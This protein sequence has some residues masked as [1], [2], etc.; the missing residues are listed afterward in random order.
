MKRTILVAL[1]AFA[2]APVAAGAAAPSAAQNASS[3]CAALKAKMGA[4][5]F[6][7]AYA[8]F[9]Q[10]VSALTP[11]EQQNVNG[12]QDACVAEQSDTN[13]AAT[14]GGKTFAQFY[15]TGKNGKD[16]LGKCVSSKAQ[17][18][19]AAEQAGTPNP[20]QTCRTQRT[21]MGTK[22]FDKT[23]GKNANDR[24]AF[25]KCVSKAAHAQAQNES[26]AATLCRSE[27]SDSNFASSHGGKTFAQFYG[28]NADD[29]NAF[30]QCV[31]TKTT[32]TTQ[33]QQQATVTAASACATEQSANA[34]A[35]RTKYG[36]F[37]ECVSLHAS[38]H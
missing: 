32:A 7:Q 36:T 26:N 4:T 19:S 2:L 29:S 33:S 9:G 37:G 22:L 6:T 12:A 17:A 20:A 24:N 34:A 28:T 5:A 11:V 18:S 16:A 10:C 8:T 14:H 25:G 27:Q 1:L 15:G 35:F 3:S 30:G 38:G 21:Q 31:S 23:Y 13:F